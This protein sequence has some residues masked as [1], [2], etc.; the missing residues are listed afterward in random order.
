MPQRVP[1]PSERLQRAAAEATGVDL[2]VDE[3]EAAVR[4]K[5]PAD[6]PAWQRWLARSLQ[7]RVFVVWHVVARK[8]SV[9][10]YVCVCVCST[11][12]EALTLAA[13]W[14]PPP[15]AQHTTTPHATPPTQDQCRVPEL[16]LVWLFTL[17]PTRLLV[18]ALVLAGGKLASR[19]DL[20][21]VYILAAIVVAIFTHGLGRKREGEASAYRCVVCVRQGERSAQRLKAQLLW[22]ARH[23]THAHHAHAHAHARAPPAPST[24]APRALC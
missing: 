12:D 5:L 4:F 8:V 19:Y 9:C 13:T 16:L 20:G 18:L 23:A 14:R 11:V 3:D 24:R 1:A 17:G 6:A 10:V 2:S 7:A 21:P 22:T 15:T